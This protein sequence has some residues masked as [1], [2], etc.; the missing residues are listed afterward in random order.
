[1][2][3]IIRQRIFVKQIEARAAE[4]PTLGVIGFWPD[5][6]EI[7]WLQRELQGKALPKLFPP[8][9]ICGDIQTAASFFFFWSQQSSQRLKDRVLAAIPADRLAIHYG[10]PS[11]LIQKMIV[12]ANALRRINL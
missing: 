12:K 2:A 11:V 8:S 5:Q 4:L 1:M 9:A 7:E 3:T 6:P 10:G